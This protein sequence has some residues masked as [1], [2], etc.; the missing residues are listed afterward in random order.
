[1]RQ[2]SKS[3]SR[4]RKS[5]PS[6]QAAR[7]PAATQRPVLLLVVLIVL[8]FQAI[9]LL[10]ALE[11][12]PTIKDSPPAVAA[13][14]FAALGSCAAVALGAFHVC[15]SQFSPTAAFFAVVLWSAAV[16]LI[17]ALSLVGATDLGKFY[18]ASGEVYFKSSWGFFALLWDGTAHYGLQLYL[19]WATLLDRPRRRVGLFWSG[20]ILNS[21]PVL[22]LGAATGAYSAEIQPST[23]LNAPY[24]CVPLAYL[25]SIVAEPTGAADATAKR[26]ATAKTV[27]SPAARKMPKATAATI[28]MP[29]IAAEK[30]AWAMLH[31]A[32]MVL[33]CWRAIVALGSESAAAVQWTAYIDLALHEPKRPSFGFV[34]VQ[35]LTFAF[36]FVPFHLYAIWQLLP[37]GTRRPS[38]RLATWAIVAAGAYAQAQATSLGSAALR[39]RDFGPLEPTALTAPAW[40][41]GAAL[42]ILPMAFAARVPF[43]A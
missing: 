40:A 35:C 27:G 37:L 42:A 14:G 10:W 23:A 24:V 26:L 13:V 38:P 32:V 6:T 39:W 11:A 20:S 36:Y 41:L 2:R 19:A 30:A 28:T 7:S 25:A 3:P 31:A 17:L 18:V 8:S 4:T 43:L 22:L 33:H 5:Q 15:G 29:A 34:R 21:M 16:D 1:M 9:T 12:M